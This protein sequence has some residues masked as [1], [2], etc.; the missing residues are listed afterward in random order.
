MPIKKSVKP[1]K[2]ALSS[3][4]KKPFV[5]E[6]Q[7]VKKQ[8][9]KNHNKLFLRYKKLKTISPTIANK[10]MARLAFIQ[11]DFLMPKILPLTKMIFDK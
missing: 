6:W 5:S 1:K 7:P 10:F 3:L 8:K 4:N 2:V 9:T 11:V